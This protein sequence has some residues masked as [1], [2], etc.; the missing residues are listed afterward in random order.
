MSEPCTLDQYV[1]DLR[2]IT[3]KTDNENKIIARVGPLAKRMATERTWLQQSHF[4]T[5]DEQGFLAHLL[6]EEPD[7]KQ[8]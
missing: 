8:R 4:Q 5:E 7:C 6:Y 2:Q 1:E 3:R